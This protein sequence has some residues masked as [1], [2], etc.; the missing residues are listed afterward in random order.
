MLFACFFLY[1]LELTISVKLISSTTY[2]LWYWSSKSAALGMGT[3]TLGGNFSQAIFNYFLSWFLYLCRCHIQL[4]PSSNSYLI[5]LFFWTMLRGWYSFTVWSNYIWVTFRGNLKRQSRRFILTL[6]RLFLALFLFLSDKL[7]AGLCFNFL[8]LMKLL[9]SPPAPFNCL[10]PKTALAL[11]LFLGLN[12]HTFF[13]RNK[14]NSFGMISKALC[15]YHS[16]TELLCWCSETNI[17]PLLLYMQ[18]AD[19][20]R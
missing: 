3:V 15:C 4:L 1:G 16:Q 6:G 2:R 10:P 17:A 12:F 19:E 14:F 13:P 7:L 8:A 5:I 9:L 18:C 11:A 20:W